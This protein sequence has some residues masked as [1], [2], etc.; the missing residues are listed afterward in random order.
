MFFSSSSIVL[1]SLLKREVPTIPLNTQEAA[2]LTTTDQSSQQDGVTSSTQPKTNAT[3]HSI[4][5]P[6]INNGTTPEKKQE[7]IETT[8]IFQQDTNKNTKTTISDKYRES[9]DE[10]VNNFY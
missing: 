10:E 3:V 9:S 1:I 6:N 2:V 8:T 4:N 5:K 7:N